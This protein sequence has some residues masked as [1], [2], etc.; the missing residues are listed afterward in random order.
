MDHASSGIEQFFH[1]KIVDGYATQGEVTSLKHDEA[2]AQEKSPSRFARFDMEA[3][4]PA[5]PGRRFQ[6]VVKGGSD[7]RSS[8]IRAAVKMIDVTVRFEIA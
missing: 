8:A 1:G 5:I 2:L 6:L 7:A 3:P 4:D